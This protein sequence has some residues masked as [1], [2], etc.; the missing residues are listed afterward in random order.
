MAR[1][2]QPL[3]LARQSYRRRRLSDAAKVLPLVGL[4]FF[5]MPILWAGSGTTSGG[6]IFIFTV[7]GVLI[8]VIAILSPRLSDSEPEQ[9]APADPGDAER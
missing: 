1:P 8:G 9:E 4:G 2:G 3:F 5:L 7:W 6:L